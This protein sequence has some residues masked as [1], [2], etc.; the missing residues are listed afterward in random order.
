MDA[1]L[2]AWTQTHPTERPAV[3]GAQ[4]VALVLDRVWT[5]QELGRLTGLPRGWQ[6]GLGVVACCKQALGRGRGG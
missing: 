1:L 4:K 3:D 6:T 2:E 5:P